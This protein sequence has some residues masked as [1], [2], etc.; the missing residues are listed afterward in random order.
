MKFL[1]EKSKLLNA[2]QTVESVVNERATLPILSNILV[3]VHKTTLQLTSTDLDIG[4]CCELPVQGMEDGGIAV[5]ARKFSE[6]TKE[7]PEGV[8]TLQAKKNNTL[9]IECGQCLFRLMGL[10]AEE[11]PRLPDIHHEQAIHLP[12]RQL[13]DMVTQTAFAM[14]HEETRYIL[15][16]ILLS[17]HDTTAT[18][19][20][21]DGRRLALAE[22]S[23]AQKTPHTKKIIVPAK[24][25]RQLHHLL[26]EEGNIALVFLGENQ[27]AF[28]MERVTLISRLIDGEFPNYEKVIPIESKRK[29]RLARALFID[30]ARRASLFTAPNSQAVRLDVAKNRMTLFKES[31]EFGEV[32]EELDVAYDAESLSIA[33]NP[34]YLLDALKVVKSDDIE[35]EL[36][37]ADKPGV[38]R[39][40][41]FLYMVLPMQVG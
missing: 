14:S 24:T 5:P 29:V 8:V 4:I 39:Q 23:L 22:G 28:Q 17:L 19:V 20:A 13:K 15:N 32:K 35:L 3:Q 41:G 2:I 10:P 30:A 7:L 34:A 6:I 37:G 38:I 12:Q 21:T 27:V 11:F 33:F 40:A 26:Q 16:S 36:S 9:L 31:P 1:V 25:V 18:I